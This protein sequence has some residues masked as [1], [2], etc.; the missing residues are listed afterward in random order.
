MNVVTFNNNDYPAFQ[1]EGNAA[2]FALPFAKKFCSGRGVDV[3]FH[4]EEWKYPGAI[5]AD[6]ADN[7]NDY[8]A[9]NLPEDLDY[10]HSSHCLEHLSDWV[11]GVE[12]WADRL[13]P[14]GVLFLYLPHPDQEY[15]LPWNNRKHLHILYPKDVKRCMVKFG[16]LNVLTS[17]RDLNHSYIIVG[18][19]K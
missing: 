15:W 11:G 18:E 14:G 4:K 17:E 16:F 10:I 1:A 7:S 6:L 9:M 5:G 13:V 19:K 12:Y 2:Q 8:H 3:G